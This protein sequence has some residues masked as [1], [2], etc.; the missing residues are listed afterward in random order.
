M[1]GDVTYFSKESEIKVAAIYGRCVEGN[2]GWRGHGDGDGNG[3]I[4]I[5]KLSQIGTDF[6][7]IESNRRVCSCLIN[8]KRLVVQGEA[9]EL[10]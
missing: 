5:C 4:F 8:N 7:G 1:E 9:P 3:K 6:S 2:D 10:E